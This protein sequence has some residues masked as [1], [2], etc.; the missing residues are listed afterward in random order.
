VKDPKQAKQ[1][2]PKEAKLTPEMIM[3]QKMFANPH[4]EASKTY[5]ELLNTR[6]C[7]D[8]YSLMRLTSYENIDFNFKLFEDTK[9][10]TIMLF[11][12]ELPNK[13]D[14]LGKNTLKYINWSKNYFFQKLNVTPNLNLD[15]RAISEI[16]KNANF[17]IK[18]FEHISYGSFLFLFCA[19][20]VKTYRLDNSLSKN[21]IDNKD[22]E[23]IDNIFSNF[24]TNIDHIY[25]KDE[26]KVE[27]FQ[28]MSVSH[29]INKINSEFVNGSQDMNSP[30]NL[31]IDEKDLILKS[32]IK[33][34][35]EM[36]E[37]AQKEKDL[38]LFRQFPGIGRY[39]MPELPLKEEFYRKAKKCEIYPFLNIGVP[40]Y[41]KYEILKRYEEVFK[42]KIPEQNFDFSNRKYQE[43]MDSN[44]LAQTLNQAVVFDQE[45]L[46]HYNERD[47][48]LLFSSYYRC[49]KGR[50]YRKVSKY[51][52]LSKP[53]FENW[54]K[55][56]MPKLDAARPQ[57]S[58][59]VQ[60]TEVKE[61]KV[62]E[63]KEEKKD[64][65]KE[66][67]KE[68]KKDDKKLNQAPNNA[69][70]GQPPKFEPNVV[71]PDPV[72]VKTQVKPV[73]EYKHDL[74][75]E[76]DDTNVGELIDKTKYMFPSDNGVIIKK[77]IKNGI[78]FS[79][80]NYIIKDNLMF[81]IRDNSNNCKELWI[82][83]EN[84]VNMIVNYIGDYN[85]KAET[86]D[87]RNGALTTITYKNGLAVQ[88]LPD[89]DI[90]Q[91]NYEFNDEKLTEDEMHRIIT[92]KASVIKYFPMDKQQ[93][94]YSNA[95]VCTIQNGI[96]VNTNN[97]VRHF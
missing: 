70:T 75:Y 21:N 20:I 55:M 3:L 58:Q 44:L 19:N 89:G 86:Y 17:T 57:P 33:N 93:I 23:E 87:K 18:D 26:S 45:I 29:E 10:D 96:S 4:N 47:D 53:D 90:C 71:A 81:G 97:K 14:A 82:R 25:Q 50:I 11:H 9:K 12:D 95:N 64:P 69:N 15:E 40:L 94:I 92:S 32:C 7:S 27:S 66:E 59:P 72:P 6:N 5:Q 88:V 1:A 80:T 48:N 34:Y 37:I 39:L 62:E 8:K 35:L 76:A 49:P 78:Y 91:K 13:L 65:K 68:D 38:L 42:E 43:F 41:E 28:E 22:A 16:L 73:E 63:K 85:Q 67:K 52:Y 60:Q 51:R 77:Y 24:S 74:L 56:V 54:R 83:F 61:V 30:F 31:F 84:E 2:P 79:F 46:L 36:I